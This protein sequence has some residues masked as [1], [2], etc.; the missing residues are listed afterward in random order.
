MAHAK[1]DAQ[2]HIIPYQ[3][4]HQL[5]KGWHVRGDY[6]KGFGGISVYN[7]APAAAFVQGYWQQGF[8][9]DT[10]WASAPTELQ[11]ISLE[12]NDML[13]QGWTKLVILSHRGGRGRAQ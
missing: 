13:V 12:A 11:R 10:G 8:H 5:V 6:G 9:K 3:R 7:E 1:R 4:T 2:G